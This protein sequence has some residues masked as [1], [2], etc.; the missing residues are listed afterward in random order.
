M[1]TKDDSNTLTY[2]AS[3]SVAISGGFS[4]DTSI[5]YLVV[6]LEDPSFSLDGLDRSIDFEPLS[7]DIDNKL[8]E[9]LSKVDIYPEIIAEF[10]GLDGLIMDYQG[11]VVKALDA[12]GDLIDGYSFDLGLLEGE[13]PTL[14][15]M[16]F[17]PNILD[18]I[19]NPDTAEI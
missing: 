16:D 9:E 4:N 3:D 7:I 6:D 8:R 5:D 17:D 19:K 13:N 10:K 1:I 18:L 14:D 2:N 15:L 12:N 11:V